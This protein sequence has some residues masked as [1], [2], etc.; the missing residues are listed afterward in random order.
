MIGVDTKDLLAKY[1]PVTKGKTEPHGGDPCCQ[2]VKLEDTRPPSL[3]FFF[4][5]IYLFIWLCP[6]L[7]AACGLFSCSR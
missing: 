5:F 6:V 1:L 2:G 4:I 7:V 3:L